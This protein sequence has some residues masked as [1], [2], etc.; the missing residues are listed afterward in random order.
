MDAETKEA[1][2]HW[3]K[4]AADQLEQIKWDRHCCVD[5]AKARAQTYENAARSIELSEYH[6]EPYC[7]CCLI[8]IRVHWER[9]YAKRHP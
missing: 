2:D 9:V 7:A 6:G 5:A 4:L 3:R 1:I 8:P